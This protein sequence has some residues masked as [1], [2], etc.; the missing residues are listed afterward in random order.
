MHEALHTLYKN[1]T[2]WIQRCECG[3]FHVHL[4]ATTLRLDQTAFE[5][6]LCGL[7]E[8]MSQAALWRF[9][10]VGAVAAGMA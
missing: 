2:L 8:A 5:E 3:V 10:S 6:L 4:G 9:S 7:G 1:D